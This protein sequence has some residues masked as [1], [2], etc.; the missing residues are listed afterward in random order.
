MTCTQPAA[1][2][3]ALGC[4]GLSVNRDQGYPRGLWRLESALV[5]SCFSIVTK[6]VPGKFG[7]LFLLSFVFFF[8]SSLG[9][10]LHSAWSTGM[11]CCFCDILF[12]LGRSGGFCMIPSWYKLSHHL[13]PTRPLVSIVCTLKHVNSCYKTKKL[14]M[15]TRSSF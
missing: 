9:S 12:C 10:S 8:S 3:Q 6:L 13:C 1:V 5:G 11:S 7:T 14:F 2:A 15:S 4:T